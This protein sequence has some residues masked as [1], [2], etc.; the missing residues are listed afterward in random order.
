MKKTWIFVAVL[1]AF[2]MPFAFAAGGRQSSGGSNL[3][4]IITPGHDNPF[5]K[6][7]ADSSDAKAKELGYQTKV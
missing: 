5:F 4:V 6:T 3:I 2:V 1:L 7:A